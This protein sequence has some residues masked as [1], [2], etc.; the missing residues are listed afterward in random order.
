MKKRPKLIPGETSFIWMLLVFSLVT[1]ILACRISGFSS[2]SSPG[3][4]PMFSSAVM[5]VSVVWIGGRSLG[6][7][8]DGTQSLKDEVQGAAK[9]VV[10]PVF[11]MYTG[12]VILYMFL[13]VPLTF[14]PASFG[15]LALAMIFLRGSSPG[16]SLLISGLTI[17]IIYLVF[18]YLFRVVLP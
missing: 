6:G 11:L 18:H 10:P 3:A 5:L 9:A 14:L 7:K 2:A 4:F 12:L 1:L 15:F 17:G 13:I 8:K 16:K